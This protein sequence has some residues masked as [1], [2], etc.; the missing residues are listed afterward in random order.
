MGVL[1]QVHSLVQ[2]AASNRE[3]DIRRAMTAVDPNGTTVRDKR[4][5][6]IANVMSAVVDSEAKYLAT[7]SLRDLVINS[8][9]AQK[10][11]IGTLSGLSCREGRTITQSIHNHLSTFLSDNMSRSIYFRNVKLGGS[12]GIPDRV[13]IVIIDPMGKVPIPAVERYLAA[14]NRKLLCGHT[15]LDITD[16]KN[17]EVVY[18]ASATSVVT[19]G[20][21]VSTLPTHHPHRKCYL[22]P[23]MARD[24]HLLFNV[25][26]S[27]RRVTNGPA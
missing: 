23:E 5:D 4:L 16:P 27:L 3:R 21:G 19:P 20:N 17:P 9:E 8:R 14:L 24:T 1:D 26:V 6:E 22:T 25:L 10:L 7:T 2:Q 12:N 13:R 15:D 11:D 18:W